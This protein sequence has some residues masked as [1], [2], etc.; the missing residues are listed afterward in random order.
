[1]LNVSEILVI[2]SIQTSADTNKQNF[3]CSHPQVRNCFNI[4]TKVKKFHLKF[5]RA[6]KRDSYIE[7]SS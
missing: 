7:Y 3:D 4:S 5:I 2:L 6:L 1:M